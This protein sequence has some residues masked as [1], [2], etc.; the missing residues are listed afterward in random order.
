MRFLDV[1]AGIG[2]MSLGCERAGWTCVGQVEV[3]A[4]CRVRQW[5]TA[6]ATDAAASGGRHAAPNAHPGT[7]LTDA[8]VHGGGRH[9]RGK[10]NTTGKP[11][12]RLNPAW[13]LQLQGFPDGW[14]D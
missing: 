12:A 10:H 8:V 2:G 7:S 6:V 3:D 1:F 9:R 14:L 5:P 13:V 11:R 4:Y